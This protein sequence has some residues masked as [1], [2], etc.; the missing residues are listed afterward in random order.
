MNEN[1]RFFHL[2][3]VIERK[4]GLS[5]LDAAARSILDLVIERQ[6]KG[7]RTTAGDLIS[8][9]T[10]SR[11]SVYRKIGELKSRGCINESWDDYQLVYSAGDGISDI[12]A[13]LNGVLARPSVD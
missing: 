2:L 7:E 13:E 11:A 12:Y 8:A 1:L 3:S 10:I 5:E 9:A 6:V 4:H